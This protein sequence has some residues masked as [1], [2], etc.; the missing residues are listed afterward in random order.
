MG[1][2]GM[3]EG[4]GRGASEGDYLVKIKSEGVGK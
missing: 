1:G 3:E 4:G 2:G